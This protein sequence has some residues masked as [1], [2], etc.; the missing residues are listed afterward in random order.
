MDIIKSAGF[1]LLLFYTRA[2]PIEIFW[3]LFELA[4]KLRGVRNIKVLYRL[5]IVV[6]CIF[7]YLF[8]LIILISPLVAFL[9]FLFESEMK[10]LLT[11]LFLFI[12]NGKNNLSEPKT[13]R[14]PVPGADRPYLLLNSKIV[15][16]SKLLELGKIFF[17]SA[18]IL[19]ATLFSIG[20][21]ET[22][23]VISSH[24]NPDL[25]DILF[26]GIGSKLLFGGIFTISLSL[27]YLYFLTYSK[28]SIVWKRR[29]ALSVEFP[30]FTRP[31]VV[32]SSIL[33]PYFFDKDDSLDQNLI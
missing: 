12:K 23:N 3:K 28:N 21:I 10:S 31:L 26:S 14:L 32:S 4:S 11:G 7:S 6:L 9:N 24:R 25:F 1:L 13:L 8:A 29:I 15:K 2:V 22:I 16:N 19:G 5:T 27:F 33:H 20:S 18:G 30:K 17:V